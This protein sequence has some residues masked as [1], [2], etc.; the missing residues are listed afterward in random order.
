MGYQKP[1]GIQ[2]T[3]ERLQTMK[4][5]QIVT[6][7]RKGVYALGTKGRKAIAVAMWSR[8]HNN[9]IGVRGRKPTIPT[10]A[11]SAGASSKLREVLSAL[12]N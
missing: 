11:K 1:A 9:Y 7:I 10:D 12:A 5:N 2:Q 3:T 4:T 8:A 6:E